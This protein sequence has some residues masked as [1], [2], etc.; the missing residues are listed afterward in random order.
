M[1]GVTRSCYKI[2]F[3]SLAVFLASIGL[4]Y[5]SD[6]SLAWDPNDPEP[7][8]YR[9]FVRQE[10]HSFN[11]E[12]PAWEGDLTTCIVPDLVEGI[13]YYFVVRAFEGNLESADSNEVSCTPNSSQTDSDQDGVP[14]ALDRF[15]YDPTEWADNDGDGTGNN[16]DVDDDNDGMDDDWEIANGLDPY[17]DD[18]DLDLDGDGFTNIEEY[19]SN[20]DPRDNTQNTAPD[21]PLIDSIQPTSNVELMPVLLTNAFFDEDTD[22][23]HQTRWQISSTVDFSELILDVTS[24]RQLTAFTV[25]AMVLDVDTRYFWRAQFIDSRQGVSEWSET[26]SFETIPWEQ[27]GDM[28]TNG[29]PDAQEVDDSTDVDG[30]GR[31]DNSEDD[32]MCLTSV[33]GHAIVGVETISE[34]AT[35][36]AAKSLSTRDLTD[37]SVPLAFGLIGFKLYLHGDETTASVRLH[38]SESVDT[39]SSVYKYNTDRGWEKYENALFSDD[40]KSVIL[41]LDDGGIG[42]EDGVKNG[43]IVDPSGVMDAGVE[44]LQSVESSAGGGGGCFI[45]STQTDGTASSPMVF[46]ISVLFAALIMLVANWMASR[47]VAWL[48]FK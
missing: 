38:F 27:S 10:G 32:M 22:P 44:T 21:A 11:Y 14:N 29:I 2:F 16:S 20:S 45:A 19:L 6:V 23:H 24:T 31:P 26:A 28:N 42:D 34:N 1:I 46:R 4:A 35:L 37:Q 39:R 17:A 5:C 12:N 40:G 41:V 33:E 9:V 48:K 7:E 25:G 36:V 15:P 13:T 47:T 18:A 8:G 30:D 43:I 3:L